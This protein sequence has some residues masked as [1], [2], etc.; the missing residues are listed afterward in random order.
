MLIGS[1]LW[2]MARVQD[3]AASDDTAL[4]EDRCHIL[5]FV[6]WN[7]D[8]A[9]RRILTPTLWCSYSM[10]NKNH[11]SPS[12]PNRW[13]QIIMKAAEPESWYSVLH[14]LKGEDTDSSRPLSLQENR[15]MH[16]Q[17]PELLTFRYAYKTV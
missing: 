5:T 12:H 14:V 7:T 15:E 16:L 3:D 4:W 9:V 17:A 6:K 2:K 13:G 10:Q 1:D 11:D 8:T